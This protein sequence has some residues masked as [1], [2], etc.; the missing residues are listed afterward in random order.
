M[1]KVA[2]LVDFG[3]TYTK[4]VA[5]DLDAPAI[6][7]T[8]QH[9]STVDTDVTIGLERALA[10]VRGV[11]GPDIA[12]RLASSSARGGLRMVAIGLVPELTAEAARQAAL[13]AGA[14]VV[15]V[16]S[17]DLTR[18][19]VVEIESLRPDLVLLA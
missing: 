13:G 3:S 12:L 1:T 5:V 16:F 11:T 8:A 14:K 10:G 15:K 7:G 4:V 18:L 19:D 6:L 2:V 9:P 17:H